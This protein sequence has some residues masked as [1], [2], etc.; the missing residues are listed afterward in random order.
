ME[1]K[2]TEHSQYNIWYH[3]VWCPKYRKPVLTGVIEVEAKKLIAEI[4]IHEGWEI[5]AIEVLP[6][7]IHLF[8]SAPPMVA[9]TD[10]VKTIKSITAVS[11]F[12][13]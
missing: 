5:G 4:C 9:P 8:V 7:H 6:D 11:L 12:L 2:S 1:L 10:I 13:F 3:L